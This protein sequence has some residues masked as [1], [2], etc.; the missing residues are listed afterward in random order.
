MSKIWQEENKFNKMLQV[1]LFACEALAAQGLIPKD[2]LKN[3]KKNARLDVER[4]KEI[5]LKTRHDVVAF[6]VNLSSLM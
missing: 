4:I 6:I 5:E 3:I 1:E 2:A